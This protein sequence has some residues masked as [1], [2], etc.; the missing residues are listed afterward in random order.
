MSLITSG[1]IVKW[2][3]MARMSEQ[4]SIIIAH[5]PAMIAKRLLCAGMPVSAGVDCVSG[6]RILAFVKTA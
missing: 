6:I 2:R 5:Q 1:V 3:D 4:R